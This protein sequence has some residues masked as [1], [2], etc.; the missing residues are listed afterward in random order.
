MRHLIKVVFLVKK[1]KGNMKHKKTYLL[2]GES[3]KMEETK[4]QFI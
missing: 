1:Y 2:S 3:K 4:S